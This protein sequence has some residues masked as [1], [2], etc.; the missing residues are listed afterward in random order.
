MTAVE[1]H[2]LPLRSVALQLGAA[3]VLVAATLAGLDQAGTAS[4]VLL[5]VAVLLAATLALAVDEPG[6]EVLDATATPFS[7]RVGHRV[8]L[9]CA[10]AAP[11]W[12]LAL[13]VVALRG[14]DVP[15]RML[16]L[17]ALALV[18]LGVASPLRC[19]GGAGWRSRA[20]SR[21]RCSSASLSRPLSCPAR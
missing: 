1:V 9:L 14:A 4:Q 3:V 8:L 12:L 5:G 20:W 10:V 2:S 18:A 19:G 17:Q 21:G 6:A 7:A 13:A 11:I 16:S 15:V